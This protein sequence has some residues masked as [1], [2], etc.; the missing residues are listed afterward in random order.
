MYLN[1][2]RFQI[3]NNFFVKCKAIVLNRIPIVLGFQSQV[4]WYKKK[5][6]VNAINIYSD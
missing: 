6:K 1:K 2:D 5:G 3:M 4:S